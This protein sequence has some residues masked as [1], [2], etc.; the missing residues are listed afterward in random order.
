MKKLNMRELLR[1]YNLILLLLVF[2]IISTIL[3]PNFLTIDNFLNLLQQA[4]IPGIVAIGMT[5]VVL[6]GGIDLSVGSVLAFAGMVSSMVAMNIGG[7]GGL[8]LAFL[9]GLCVSGVMGLITGLLISRFK[10]PDFIA[11]LAMMEIGRGAALLTTSGNPVFGL[12]EE[13]HE[14]GGGFLLDK[15]AYTAIIWIILTVVFALLFKYTIFGRSLFAI[16]GNY[17]AAMLSGIKTKRNYTIAYILSGLL[18]GFAGILTASWMSTGQP[19]AG[20]GYELDAIAAS[21]IGGA[22]LSGGKGSVIGTFGGVFLLQ[23]ITNIF[24]LVGLP[25]YY[26]RIAKGI[27]IILALLLNN[28]V[29]SEQ[30]KK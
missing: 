2:M 21:V 1:K 24:N 16:G 28:F 14:I 30:K 18:S 6:L 10:L 20:N 3:S 15:L 22:S 27:I 9:A 13:F 25:S 17:E 12:S 11:S 29:S 19:T 7:I 5:T 8:L 23:I 26:Q 4:S